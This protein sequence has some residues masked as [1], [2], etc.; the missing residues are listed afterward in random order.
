M[1]G[2]FEPTHERWVRRGVSVYSPFV[3]PLLGTW[4]C[5]EGGGVSEQLAAGQAG[6]SMV[7]S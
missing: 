1:A 5:S 2:A 4:V 7:R 3:E 6:V